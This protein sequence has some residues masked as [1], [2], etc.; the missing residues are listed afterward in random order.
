MVMGSVTG[1][2][3]KFMRLALDGARR[4]LGQ[5]SPN[6]AV[7]AVIVSRGRVLA[8]GTHWAAGGPH[9]EIEALRALRDGETARGA[10]IYVTLEPCS[11]HGRTPPCTDA[12]IEAGIARVVYGAKDPNPRHQGRARAIFEAAGIEVRDGVLEAECREM[13]FAWN[14]WITTGLPF[15]TAKCGMTLDGRIASRPDARWITS[16]AARKDAM[17]LRAECDAIL[18]GGGTVRD[19]N[20][21]LTVRG[22]RGARQPLRIVWTKSGE[23]PADAH[24]LTDD[25]SDRT[26]VFKG[27]SLRSVFKKL[28]REGVTSLLIE[29]G[30]RTLG[31]AFDRRLVNRIV[32]YLAPDLSGGPVPAVGGLGVNSSEEG[33]KI[34]RMT[35]QPVGRDLRV[36]GFL[37]NS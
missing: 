28:G 18:V 29:G 4:A 8:R 11:T 23:I 13:N 26:R 33:F 24:L 22:I 12:V 9:A 17:R 30:G 27:C 21:K 31:E 10:T 7:G 1:N 2:D 16:P 6:P 15:V 20:P 25:G 5:T 3:E 32:F 34:E 36:E 14:H 19:D 37:A 35:V